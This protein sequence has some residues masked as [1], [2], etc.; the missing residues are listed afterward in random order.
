MK[1]VAWIINM[2]KI[3]DEFNPPRQVLKL[4]FRQRR[5]HSCLPFLQFLLHDSSGPHFTQDDVHMPLFTLWNFFKVENPPALC[6]CQKWWQDM[7]E[8]GLFLGLT[9][10]DWNKTWYAS[11]GSAGCPSKIEKE[12]VQQSMPCGFVWTWPQEKHALSPLSHIVPMKVTCFGVH[13]Y[14]PESGSTTFQICLV[15]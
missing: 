10:L 11:T 6:K 7:D 5:Y 3:L 15:L 9:M 8:L 4:H 2:S 14:F 12:P 13:R 1:R